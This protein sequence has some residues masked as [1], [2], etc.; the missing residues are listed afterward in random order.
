MD[1]AVPVRV[2][3]GR[4]AVE[5][6]L[7]RRSAEL[8]ESQRT[9]RAKR[10]VPSPVHFIDLRER[11]AAHDLRQ[12]LGQHV[13]DRLAAHQRP[14]EAVAPLQLVDRDAVPRANPRRPSSA[15]R[16]RRRRPA[17][18]AR[19]C[20]VGRPLGQVVDDDHQPPRP[21]VDVGRL[22]A[23]HAPRRARAA[24]PRASRQAS[25]GSS[26]QPIS[27]TSLRQLALLADTTSRYDCATCAPASRTRPMYAARSVTEIAPRASS[28]LNVCE[29][30]STWS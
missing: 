5:R 15:C 28:R 8:R 10:S 18:P 1:P 20:P 23:E 25:A 14:H 12:P 3:A 21:D 30:F 13:G 6:R 16:P 9:G 7:H 24:A 29:H 17:L 27:N 11:E 26:S 2:P 22:G 19:A 4:D